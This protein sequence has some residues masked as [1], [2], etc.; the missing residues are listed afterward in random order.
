VICKP[1]IVVRTE[2]QEIATVNDHMTPLPPFY[3]SELAVKPLPLQYGDVIPYRSQQI[4][5]P[6]GFL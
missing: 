5:S 3:Q 1:E 4:F 2:E 6:E